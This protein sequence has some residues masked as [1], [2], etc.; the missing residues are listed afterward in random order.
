MPVGNNVSACRPLPETYDAI[1]IGSGAG[2]GPLA[3]R[4]AESGLRVLILEKGLNHA[5]TDYEHDTLAVQRENVFCPDLRHDPHTVVTRKS[6]QPTRTTLGWIASCVGGGTAHLGGYY[7][8]F[9][10]D[11]FRMQSVFGDYQQLADW[12]YNY[13]ELEPY[14]CIAEWAVG[15]SGSSTEEIPGI[16]RSQAYPMAPLASHPAKKALQEKLSEH[17]LQSFTTPRC[18]NS[19][20][21]AD[22]PAC[23]YCDVCAGFGCPVGAKGSTQETVLARALDYPDCEL[24]SSAMVI[25]ITHAEDGLANG[26]LF[27]DSDQQSWSA[28]AQI[29]CVCCS[30]VESARLLMLSAS[31]KYPGGIGNNN[32]LVG[33]YLQFHATSTASARFNLADCQHLQL[34]QWHPLLG[35]SVMDHY[36]LPQ[37]VADI[38]KGGLLRFDMLPL[39]PVDHVDWL[40]YPGEPETHDQPLWGKPLMQQLTAYYQRYRYMY[41]EAF[42]DFI[43][44]ADTFVELDRETVDQWGL[45]VAKIHLDTPAHHGL[46]G[47]WLLERAAEVFF[48]LG[49]EQVRATDIGGTASYLV[50]GTCRAGHD[51]DTSVLNAFCQ[52]HEV[53]NLFV[54]DGSFMPTSGGAP[55]TLTILANSFR[56]ADHIVSRFDSGVFT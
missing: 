42:H 21:Y 53:E 43:P 5:R 15:V 30:A 10:P 51:P 34:E 40:L 37:G 4:L 16:H 22:R 28:S 48:E 24:I 26:C 3:L 25:R 56:V 39:N 20:P 50:H 41:V 9:H 33:K 31:D 36:F 14:Y 2:G 11:D 35:Q 52:S 54:V 29:I 49:A 44:N 13:T 1:I 27:I 19:E 32:G 6:T 55:P 18:I 38:H 23:T 8:R 45:P 12:P 46:V 7:Y 17:Q 47:Q